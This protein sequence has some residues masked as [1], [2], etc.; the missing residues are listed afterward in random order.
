MHQSS[1]RNA[2]RSEPRRKGSEQP[3]SIGG[4]SD[5]AQSV[6][7]LDFIKDRRPDPA[8]DETA[9]N[10]EAQ[11]PEIIIEHPNEVPDC[12]RKVELILQ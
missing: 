7:A 11:G 4:G 8:E 3:G 2:I 10:E 5:R 12:A 9:D 1:A 6:V